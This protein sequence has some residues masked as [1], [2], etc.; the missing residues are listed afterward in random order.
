V[1]NG[2]FGRW[3][4]VITG[5]EKPA[6]GQVCVPETPSQNP[7]DKGEHCQRVKNKG[8]HKWLSVCARRIPNGGK[9][10]NLSAAN[11][12]ATQ[13]VWAPETRLLLAGDALE[14]GKVTTGA[15]GVRRPAGL[16][17]GHIAFDLFQH[18]ANVAVKHRAFS[19]R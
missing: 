17:R 18:L 16:G 19:F 11:G 12:G 8:N 3:P 15:P 2:Q 13:S 6:E 10:R 1:E 5:F 9:R 7:A 4:F 14:H